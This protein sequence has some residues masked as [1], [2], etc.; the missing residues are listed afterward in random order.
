[1]YKNTYPCMNIYITL[2]T[3][4]LC[5]QTKAIWHM[6]YTVHSPYV[7]VGRTMQLLT[8][9]ICWCTSCQNTT[10]TRTHTLASNVSHTHTFIWLN[11]RK[12][13][14]GKFGSFRIGR[15]VVLNAECSVCLHRTVF[16][17]IDN[18]VTTEKKELKNFTKF[19]RHSN[20]QFCNFQM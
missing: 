9:G 8:T 11:G 13:Y 1:M 10:H 19:L 17:F 7:L 15:M 12:N 6:Q 16:R 3:L 18:V 14:I 2:A 4:G 5:E 20:Y